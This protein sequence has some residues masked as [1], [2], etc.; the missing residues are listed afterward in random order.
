MKFDIKISAIDGG[1]EGFVLLN[2]EVVY[3]T[4]KLRSVA[5]V[6][7]A[8]SQYIAA[9]Q[10]KVKDFYAPRGKYSNMAARGCCGRG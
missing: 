5:E 2:G 4:E 10:S 6:S 1:Y 3:T 9:N 8:T 7:A